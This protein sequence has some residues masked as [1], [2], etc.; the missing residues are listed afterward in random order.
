MTKNELIIPFDDGFICCPEFPAPCEY[1]R[2]TDDSGTEIAYWDANEF[3]E[4]PQEVL[5]AFLGCLVGKRKA[6]K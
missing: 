1:V 2:V 5:G 4:S 6:R 3:R